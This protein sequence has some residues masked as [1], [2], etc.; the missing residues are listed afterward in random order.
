MGFGALPAPGFGPPAFPNGVGLQQFTAFL[1]AVNPAAPAANPQASSN[2]TAPLRLVQPRCFSWAGIVE[3]FSPGNKIR[4]L[5]K[6]QGRDDDDDELPEDESSSDIDASFKELLPRAQYFPQEQ[7]AYKVT[8]L[9]FKS[10]GYI[11]T[12]VDAID[13]NE[14][15]PSADYA[16]WSFETMRIRQ[17]LE[18]YMLTSQDPSLGRISHYMKPDEIFALST[19]WGMDH[20]WTGIYPPEVIAEAEEDGI[21]HPGRARFSGT[22][23]AADIEDPD[24]MGRLYQ[25]RA[26]RFVMPAQSEEPDMAANL[27]NMLA[28]L[29]NNP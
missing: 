29:A 13:N 3:L 7:K 15:Y 5:M 11:A 25:T 14:V 9:S 8:S 18:T 4:R 26:E 22:I 6:Q 23:K 12:E 21:R 27:T 2:D 28:L 17:Q 20:G 19:A 16:S 24:I 1:A 10:C